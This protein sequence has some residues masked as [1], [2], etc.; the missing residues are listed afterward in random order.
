MFTLPTYHKPSDIRCPWACDFAEEVRLPEA[1]RLCA[2]S[3]AGARFGLDQSPNL[4][5]QTILAQRRKGAEIGVGDPILADWRRT[6]TPLMQ[7]S[8]IQSFRR[9]SSTTSPVVL[10]SVVPWSGAKPL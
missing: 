7:P 8:C 9:N 5:P 10:W 2:L 3:E 4:N 1:W 6:A